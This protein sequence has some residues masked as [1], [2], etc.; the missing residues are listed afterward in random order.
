MGRKAPACFGDLNLDQIV[1]S[2]T[3]GREEYN[4]TP[5]FYTPLSRVET[6]TYRHGILRDFENPALFG[7]IRL[8]AQKMRAMRQHLAQ[9]EELHYKYEKERW[10]LEAVDI[11]C[12]AVGCLA[13][14][15]TMRG[16]AV[17]RLPGV[18]RVSDVLHEIARLC[19]AVG[20]DAGVKGRS[21]H[22]QVLPAN[23]GKARQ[24]QPI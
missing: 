6:I 22:H 20:R 12:D 10:F 18:A 7:H 3:A 9:A 17:A 13:Q 5:F 16:T 11:Y 19:V 23:Q 1:A 8:F 2:I 4:L 24:G 15:L 21:L 14:D